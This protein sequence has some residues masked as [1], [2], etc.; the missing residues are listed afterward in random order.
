LLEGKNSC[1]SKSTLNKS[2]KKES[3]SIMK[4]LWYYNCYIL[5]P[6]QKERRGREEEK[7]T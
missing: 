5:E 1:K 7:I 2:I 4:K 3:S 6:A